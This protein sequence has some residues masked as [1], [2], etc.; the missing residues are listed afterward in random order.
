MN[1]NYTIWSVQSNGVEALVET[2]GSL[3]K[4]EFMC[5]ELNAAN[6]TVDYR[7]LPVEVPAN[8]SYAIMSFTAT[9][10]PMIEAVFYT[11][12]EAEAALAMAHL[13]EPSFDYRIEEYEETAV[14]KGW[15]VWSC[16]PGREDILYASN[17]TEADAEFV[18]TECNLVADDVG[19]LVEFRPAPSMF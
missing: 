6:D 9:Q 15:C 10:E 19:D 4:A 5:S 14:P 18:A 13:L 11:L 7:I 8:R 17:L 12:A 3:A 16:A 2:C 1:T